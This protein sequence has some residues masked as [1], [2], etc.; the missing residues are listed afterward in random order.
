V[1]AG[2]FPTELT[3]DTGE[4]IRERG[5]EY[6]TTTGRPR[7]VGWFDGVAARFASRINGLT[8]MAIT[9]LDILDA[10]DKIKVCTG[11]RLNG[12]VVY[13]FPADAATLN[14]CRPVYEAVPGWRC[15]TTGMTRLEELPRE[16]RAYIARLE[17]LAGCQANYV[18][19]G[20]VRRQSI[21]LKPIL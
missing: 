2:P 12:D 13:D 18:C 6:G 14:Q 16:T 15:D 21:E 9:R 17:E 10:L 19:I 20:P 3:D 8:G 7:R 11:Y 5:H 4:L 1:G